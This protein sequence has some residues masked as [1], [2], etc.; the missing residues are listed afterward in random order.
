M[1]KDNNAIT[2]AVLSNEWLNLKKQSVK[3]STFIKYKTIIEVHLL[4]L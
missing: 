1:K 2:F 3:Y 4:K